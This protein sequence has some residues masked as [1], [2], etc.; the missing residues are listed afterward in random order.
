MSC[1]NLPNLEEFYCG[2]NKF[3]GTIP[4]SLSNSSRLWMLNL[5]ENGLTRTLPA[6][7]L[8]SL[9]SLVSINSS[10]NRLGSGTTG[11]LN[12]LSFLGNCTSLE[13]FGMDTN[14]FGG[15]VPSS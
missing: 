2:G 5:A 6:E 15:E 11:D 1:T 3:T 10:R 9:R 8:G 14:H 13:D 12:F 7:N 4:A